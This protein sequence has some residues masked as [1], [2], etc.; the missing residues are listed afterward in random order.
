MQYNPNLRKNGVYH[1]KKASLMKWVIS[2][3]QIKAAR[4]LLDW[5]QEDLAKSAGLPVSSVRN[6][7]AER[8]NSAEVMQAIYNELIAQ[9]MDFPNDGV[10]KR[11]VYLTEYRSYTEIL[12]DI[13]RTLSGGEEVMFDCVDD[14][15]SSQEVV[16]KLSAIR[17]AGIIIKSTICEGNSYITGLQ[18]E[19]K[20]IPAGY[21]ASNE[22]SVIY[23]NKVVQHV[24]GRSDDIFM[25][26]HSS[27]YAETMR[28]RFNYWWNSGKDI[29]L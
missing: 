23:A 16:N 7:E 15:R 1:K 5:T 10:L 19:Y 22:V 25:M 14:A 27:D 13:L 21:F 2:V 26:I 3:K 29:I 8:S 11:D 17:D 12:D 18:S 6:Y 24:K 4:A 28:K 9:G 20:W